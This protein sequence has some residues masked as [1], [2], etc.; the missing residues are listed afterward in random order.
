MLRAALIGA[1]DD[2]IALAPRLPHLAWTA[3]A[4]TDA[5][6]ASAAS[7]QLGSVATAASL[8]ELLQNHADSFDA[9]V[10]NSDADNR[11]TDCLLAAKASK[12]VLVKP[13]FANSLD[14]A[15]EVAD[16]CEANG[17]K[18][19]LAQEARFL[20]SIQ[21]VRQSHEAGQLG[22]PGAVRIHRWDTDSTDTAAAGVLQDIDL[23]LWMF[24]QLP[25]SVYA[26]G[27]A[28]GY[29]QIHLGFANDGMA[30]ID[31][32]NN[33]PSGGDYFSLTLI[34]STGA[35]YADDHHNM[36][37][38]YAGGDP[39]AIRTSLGKVHLLAMLEEF[40]TSIT[41]S[42]EPSVGAAAN[43]MTLKVSAAVTESLSQRAAIALT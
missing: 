36:N 1:A 41:E 34:G 25:T 28:D 35:A 30:L 7:Q 6:R 12:H 24:G 20:P 11:A 14:E 19:M 43:S 3:L 26:V 39:S 15:N 33:L 10:I 8:S 29:L 23:A 5:A 9:V 40:T 16:C 37:L 22:E 32:S 17:V 18:L 2:Y 38:V 21:S 27:Q 13:P 42:R 31:Y 4:D